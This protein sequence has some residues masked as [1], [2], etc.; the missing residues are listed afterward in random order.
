MQVFKFPGSQKTGQRL[1]LGLALGLFFA[2]G[3]GF[4]IAGFAD[5]VH[6]A[7]GNTVQGKLDRLTGDIIEFRRN[8]RFMGNLDYFKR[9]QLTDR[10]DVVETRDRKKYFGEIIYLDNFILEIQTSVGSVRLKRMELTD[11]VLGS[12][13]QTPTVPAM[14]QVPPRQLVTA[15]E[16]PETEQPTVRMTPVS[17]THPVVTHPSSTPNADAGEDDDAIPAVDSY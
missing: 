14:N 9:I 10:H 3:S 4:W 7:N 15:P 2:L 8:S 12:P 17:N 13:A 5:V 1:S 11:V 16:P 6:F